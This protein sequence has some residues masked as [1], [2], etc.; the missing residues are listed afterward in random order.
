MVSRVCGG[1]M[2]WGTLNKEEAAEAGEA[3]PSLPPSDCFLF[4]LT[5]KGSCR[6]LKSGVAQILSANFEDDIL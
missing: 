3:V 6:H 4:F 2:M 1:T 5:G